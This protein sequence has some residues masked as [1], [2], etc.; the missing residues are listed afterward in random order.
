MNLKL[1]VYLLVVFLCGGAIGGWIGQQSRP[2][3]PEDISCRPASR[4]ELD[5][6]YTN[7]L[8][9]SDS[10][11]SS[12]MEREK[13]YQQKRDQLAAQM[14]LAN[15]QLADLIEDEGYESP[16]IRTLVHKIHTVM[17]E[18]QELSLTHLSSIEQVLEPEQAKLLKD[19]AVSRLRQN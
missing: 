6:F 2:Q 9:V 17:G 7:I 15:M 16:G 3:Y 12:I 18:L 11:K 1:L 5:Y 19:N 8:K 13:V 4:D 10:Q 14:H